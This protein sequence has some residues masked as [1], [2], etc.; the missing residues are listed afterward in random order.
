MREIK[1][2]GYYVCK[3]NALYPEEKR[4]I[5]GSLGIQ[6]D[7][8]WIISKEEN[9][10]F[11]VAAETV[12]QYTGLHDATKWEELT[13]AE[14][15]AWVQQGSMPSEW[16]GR[17]IYE[18]DVLKWRGYEVANGKQIR[19]SRI[20]EI[21]YEY[22]KLFQVENIIRD[23]GTSEII[24]NIHENPELIEDKEEGRR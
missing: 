18:G 20:L 23:N 17:E 14:R 3:G 7:K 16:C 19:P 13:E 11:R 4:W 15:A 12:G 1:F 5:Y 22:Y 10:S 9:T 2:R 8:C 6:R 21:E 24:G